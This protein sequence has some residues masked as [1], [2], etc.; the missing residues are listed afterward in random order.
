MT[1]QNREQYK[2]NLYCNCK[3]QGFPMKQMLV[4]VL[5]YRL[6]FCLGRIIQLGR[7]GPLEITWST[8]SSKQSQV[9]Q[10][11]TQSGLKSLQ[12]RNCTASLGNL[13]LLFEHPHGVNIFPVSNQNFQ[14]SNLLT[15]FPISRWQESGCIV[16]VLF[17]WE[18]EKS[19]TFFLSYLQSWSEPVLSALYACMQCLL[20]GLLLY[21]KSLL[22]REVQNWLQDSDAFSQVLKTGK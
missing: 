15:F 6:I 5:S 13:V 19:T 22:D 9:A 7:D 14:S 12:S 21:V 18:A 3:T 8:Q 11:D 20:L 16:S 2:K 1:Q 4:P 17:H 10:R